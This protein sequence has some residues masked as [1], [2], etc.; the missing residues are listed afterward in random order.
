MR[1]PFQDSTTELQSA[2][3]AH[4]DDHLDDVTECKRPQDIQVHARWHCSRYPPSVPAPGTWTGTH[5]SVAV[6]EP[7]SNGSD[8]H[9][10]RNKPSALLAKL[11]RERSLRTTAPSSRPIRMQSTPSGTLLLNPPSTA[12]FADAEPGRPPSARAPRSPPPG[13]HRVMRGQEIS[14]HRVMRPR[15]P[16]S[17]GTRTEPY[18]ATYAPRGTR[19]DAQTLFAM[20]KGY[21]E[22]TRTEVDI[23]TAGTTP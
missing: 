16:G 2:P 9:T 11:G 17:N 5:A 6:P 22:T 21:S 10:E 8:G 3:C 15:N 4:S 23:M 1:R 14:T 19:P 20:R 7:E 18:A 12:R 13:T